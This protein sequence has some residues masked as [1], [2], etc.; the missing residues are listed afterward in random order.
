MRASGTVSFSASA[1]A[2]RVHSYEAPAGAPYT[3]EH[4]KIPSGR[5][6]ELAAT[7]T[8]PKGV[9]NPAVVI[10]ISGSGPQERD[11]EIGAVPGYA[12]FRVS[13]LARGS[14]WH[15]HCARGPL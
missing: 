1:A 4:V 7:L 13:A 14:R 10:T 8:K 3:A 2:P 12:I 11:S 5:G 9:S 6:Y 15:P